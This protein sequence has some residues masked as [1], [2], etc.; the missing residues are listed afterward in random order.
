MKLLIVLF[1]KKKNSGSEFGVSEFPETRISDSYK[2]TAWPQQRL[3]RN[4]D[5]HKAIKNVI[6]Y[7]DKQNLERDDRSQMKDPILK[8]GQ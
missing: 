2:A 6:D 5:I 3:R 4:F 8:G 7:V 1:K